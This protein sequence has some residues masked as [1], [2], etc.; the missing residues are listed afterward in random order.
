MDWREWKRGC[1]GRDLNPR[2]PGY[3][4]DALPDCATPHIFKPAATV[5]AGYFNHIGPFLFG[6]LLRALMQPVTVVTFSHQ[7]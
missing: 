3:E 1:G 2:P 5:R 7:L 6:S 4:P